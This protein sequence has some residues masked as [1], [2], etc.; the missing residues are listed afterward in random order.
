MSWAPV[1]AMFLGRIAVGF[2]VRQ[3]LVFNWIIPSLFGILWMSIFGGTSLY[4]ELIEGN[5]LISILNDHGPESIIYKVFEFLPLA[6]VFAVVFLVTVFL[7]FVTAADSNTEAMAS[8]STEGIS[9]NDNSPPV[10]LKVIWGVVI[11]I[12]SW[13]LISYAGVDGVKMLSNIGGFPAL[14]L[15]V[16]LCIALLKLII[17]KRI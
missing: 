5:D 15:M 3:F 1:T 13:V 10:Y 2:T 8:I 7:S 16:I 11:G 4:L 14:F 9:S 12:V 17:S 6:K